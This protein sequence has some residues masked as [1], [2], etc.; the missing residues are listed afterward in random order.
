VRQ[1]PGGAI[2]ISGD[3]GAFGQVR[4]GTSLR[5]AFGG[6]SQLSGS[7]RRSGAPGQAGQLYGGGAAGAVGSGIAS[8]G[9]A[10]AAGVVIV[11][12]I[13]ENGGQSI[14]E[15]YAD[16]SEH[17]VAVLDGRYPRKFIMFRLVNEYGRID[18]NAK[19]NL[20]AALTMRRRGDLVN[21][22]GYV[23]PGHVSNTTML[24]G[25]KALGFPTNSMLML[26]VEPWPDNS[27]TPLISGDH[28]TAFN[29]LASSLRA[30]QGGR[31]D[32]V[33][34][35]SYKSAMQTLWPRRPAWLGFVAA[36]YTATKPT[37]V[38]PLVAWQYTDGPINR[39]AWPSSSSPFGLCDHNALFDPIPTPKD[40]L[41]SDAQFRAL[42]EQ[43]SALHDKLNDELATQEQIHALRLQL[44]D[45]ITALAA[46]AGAIQDAIG[47]LG[48]AGG[49]IDYGQV[50]AAAEAALAKT[51]LTVD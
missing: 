29:W 34:G 1:A 27:G 13:F 26:D 46:Q 47:Q 8:A 36:S 37:W 28:S 12:A 18:A 2:N 30:R 22:G 4:G 9:S 51:R 25:I 33:V 19:A 21:F 38:S 44:Q 11:E 15:I 3:G 17:Q 42:T 35:Y 45:Q 50:Q 24:D 14:V 16:V 43:I 5:E 6:S 40:E 10:G 23:N 41:M 32:L 20:A 39:T 31:A 7:I 48:T 49:I